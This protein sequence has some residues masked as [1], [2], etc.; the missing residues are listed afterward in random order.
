MRQQERMQDDARSFFQ[1]IK[2]LYRETDQRFK[3]TERMIQAQSREIGRLERLFTSQWGRLIESLVEGDL[4][5]ML[6][7]FGL[8]VES[9][10]TRLRGRTP[11]GR[12]YEFDILAHDGDIL[13]VVEVKTTLRPEDVNDFSEKLGNF[14]TWL[15]RYAE[16]TVHGAVAY[17]QA[18]ASAVTMAERRGLLVI[19]ATG[20]SA[21]IVNS[22]G[23]WPRTW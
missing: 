21:A 18:D 12:N 7:R 6:N 17:L 5:N 1:E 10:T 20:D 14:K 22:K 4:V 9:T 11:E 19:R 23:F 15:Q 2:D 13:V 3:E 8:N 16:N